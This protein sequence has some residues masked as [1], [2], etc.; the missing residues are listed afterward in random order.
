VKEEARPDGPTSMYGVTFDFIRYLGLRQV[1]ELPDYEN[2]R[3]EENLK[4]LIAAMRPKHLTPRPIR[5]GGF[6]S[7]RLLG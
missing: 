7:W 5:R 6:R 1:S 3:N 2:L 4:K